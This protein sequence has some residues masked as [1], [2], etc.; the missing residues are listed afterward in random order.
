MKI[1][2]R[3]GRVLE[4]APIQIVQA[5]KNLALPVQHLSLSEYIDWVV[6][7]AMTFEGATLKVD[8]V[9]LDEK[10]D[11]LVAELVRTGLAFEA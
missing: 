6:D 7:R 11:A 2:M 3:D 10:S 8:G 1:R 5:M 9:G 4:G